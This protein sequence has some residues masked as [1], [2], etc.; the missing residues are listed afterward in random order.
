MAP[1]NAILDVLGS[2][3]PGVFHSLTLPKDLLLKSHWVQRLGGRVKV[4]G[5]DGDNPFLTTVHTKSGLEILDIEVGEDEDESE[6]EEESEDEDEGEE[7]DQ[8]EDVY[9]EED[10]TDEDKN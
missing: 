2:K 7:G 8:K 5:L 9:E 3:D 6:D 4:E 1:I 10:I